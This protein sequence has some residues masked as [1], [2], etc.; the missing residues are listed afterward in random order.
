MVQCVYLCFSLLLAGCR[1]EPRTLPVV[2]HLEEQLER[3]TVV[4][5]T[6][7]HLRLDSVK[8]CTAMAGRMRASVLP[9]ITYTLS[10]APSRQLVCCV[11]CALDQEA[12]GG[13]AAAVRGSGA[14]LLPGTIDP[15]LG[16]T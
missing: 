3:R 7:M 12:S 13:G 16:L 11:P 10:A 15:T 2:S 5:V 4:W 14:A 1:S 6:N 9:F 8:S